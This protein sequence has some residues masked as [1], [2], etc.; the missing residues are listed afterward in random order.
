MASIPFERVRRLTLAPSINRRSTVSKRPVRVTALAS[1][2]T[3]LTTVGLIAVLL[4]AF[5]ATT[6]FSIVN[7]ALPTIDADLH[8]SAGMLQLVVAGYGTPFAL[9]LVVGGRLGDAFGRRRLFSIGM[10]AFTLASLLC[11]LAPSI[12]WLVL[13]RAAQGA[14][15][16]MMVPQVLSTAPSGERSFWSTCPSGCLAFCS[17]RDVSRIAVR[18]SRRPSI[19]PARPCSPRRWPGG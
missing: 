1:G 15:S 3:S 18:A 5:L 13:A 16:A 17:P 2:E 7:V 10:A 4:G 19:Q 9:L 6:D 14:A 11:G 12:G 8:A